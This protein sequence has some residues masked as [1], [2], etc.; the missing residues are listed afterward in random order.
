[1]IDFA[2]PLP[3]CLPLRLVEANMTRAIAGLP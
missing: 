1:M 2:H 3:R